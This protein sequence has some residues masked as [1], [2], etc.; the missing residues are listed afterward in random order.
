LRFSHSVDAA[1]NLLGS[2][3]QNS[4][5]LNAEGLVALLIHPLQPARYA[6]DSSGSGA[7]PSGGCCPPRSHASRTRLQRIESSL[8]TV[9]LIR[10]EG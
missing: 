9:L 1:L 10:K 2:D 6:S 8:Q 4:K 3:A 5:R 7:H